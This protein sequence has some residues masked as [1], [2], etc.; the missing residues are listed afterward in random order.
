MI[1]ASGRDRVRSAELRLATANAAALAVLALALAGI[2]TLSAHGAHGADAARQARPASVSG[3]AGGFELHQDPLGARTCYFTGTHTAVPLEVALNDSITATITLRGS[4][5]HDGRRLHVVFVI[6]ASEQMV[7]RSRNW[8]PTLLADAESAVDQ[9]PP[10]AWSWV[11]IGVVSFRD[12]VAETESHLTSDS[13]ELVSALHDIAVSPG[14]E[15][16]D[17]GLREG[18]RK[19]RRALQ[20]GR[21]DE[22]PDRFR[23][24]IIVA[25]RGFEATSCEA[26]RAATNEVEPFGILLVTACGGG[27]CDRRCL[28]EA[29]TSESFAF[30]SGEWGYLGTVLSQLRE[31][32]GPFNPIE[33]VSI[34]DELSEMLLYA[35]GG[36]PSAAVGNRL[37]WHFGP[38]PSD[39]ITRTYT[40]LA[41]GVGEF[42]LS[43][44]ISATVSYNADL[45]SGRV[46]HVT[47]DN[48]IVRVV[49]TTAT[50]SPTITA[51]AS[52]TTP[53][54]TPS[55]GPTDTATR[56][57]DRD[58]QTPS[59]TPRPATPR[60]TWALHLPIA[61]RLGCAP[62]ATKVD[63]A[64]VIDVSGSMAVSD[65][66]RMASRWDAAA[67]I[68]E[69]VVLYHLAEPNDRVAVIP[70]AE[71]A[72]VRSGLGD[73]LA[74]A[75]REL[76]RLPRWNGS[77]LDL[78]VDLAAGELL[79]E[80]QAG[81]GPRPGAHKVMVL[82]TDGD[83]NM[84]SDVDLLDAADRSR[85]AGIEMIAVVLGRDARADL[86]LVRRVTGSPA[87]ILESRDLSVIEITEALGRQLRCYR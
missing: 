62:S 13:E 4:C 49:P 60:P 75:R 21:G 27:E 6:D 58:A 51:T 40:A 38:W 9:V 33:S 47:F 20:A 35:S 67:S 87:R 44:E 39:G 71:T 50:A 1:A 54:A 36:Y 63:V 31:E 8:L 46:R 10:D 85:A 81:G 45:G 5:P 32:S 61:M 14:T 84:T 23:E 80:V 37:E 19:A 34:V 24:V 77:R 79:G 18:L 64:L 66:E 28:A 59:A 69:H 29:A 74:S 16:L 76:G 57:P 68:S 11:Q 55:A 43:T 70:F 48:P 30:A 41:V 3:G 15:C 42:P 53:T 12:R 82:F 22:P 7:W 26:V 52:A 65:V 56:T 73:G 72:T 83:L 17:C 2:G 25:S 86:D 78:A